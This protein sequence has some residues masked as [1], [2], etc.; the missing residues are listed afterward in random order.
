MAGSETILLVDDDD[1]FI[2][3]NRCVLSAAGFSVLSA[4]GPR[5]ALELLARTP[6]DL[7]VS[8]L[9]M[10]SLDAGYLFCRALQQRFGRGRL[11]VVMI[12][13]VPRSS[14]GPTD[15][16]LAELGIRRYLEKP[17]PSAVLIE[18]IRSLLGPPKD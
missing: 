17:V 6:A 11:P 5:E 15:E 13:C 8:D 4:G 3:I 10:D 12:T 18:T 14:A 16:Q 7:V 2:E 9:M 1:D